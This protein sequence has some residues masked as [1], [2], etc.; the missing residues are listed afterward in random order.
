MNLKKILTWA[1][2]ALLLFFLITQPTQSADLVNGI[3]R[4]LKEAAE[5]LIT[6]VRSLF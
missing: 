6:F 5:A 4:T 1:G 3:L 2:I